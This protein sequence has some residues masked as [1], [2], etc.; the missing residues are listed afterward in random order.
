M[1]TAAKLKI[2][3][4]LYQIVSTVRGAFGLSD[5]VTA[6]R[7]GIRYELDLSEGIDL[8]IYVL[9]A[10]EPTTRRRIINTVRAG[11]V[12]LDIGANVGAHTMTLARCAGPDGHVH[13]F[14]PTQYAFEKLSRN[15]ALNPDLS[16]TITVNQA[17][18]SEHSNRDVPD[19]IY[20]SWNLKEKG[21]K[22]DQHGGFAKSTQDGVSISVDD[23]V[24]SRCLGR[25]D[26]VK[27]DVDGFECV[28]VRGARDTLEKHKPKILFELA[29]YAIT[30]RGYDPVEFVDTLL[31]HGY[32]LRH[33]KDMTPISGS[34]F[35]IV[36][37]VE[38]GASINLL[39]DRA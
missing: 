30:E 10:F 3:S 31:K 34:A 28:V 4:L 22:H 1:K 21:E 18:I 32:V 38:R 36:N 9:G 27:I 26:F 17:F 5:V 19:S 37:S 2:A 33:E 11:D 24:A 7:K 12:V 35:D 23:Y 39:A 13:A 29:P 15:V 20:S 6:Q 25:V 16:P 8:S 14:E